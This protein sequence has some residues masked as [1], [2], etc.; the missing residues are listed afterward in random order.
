MVSGIFL[1]LMF[2][3]W[4]SG[5]LRGTGARLRYTVVTLGHGK[6]AIEPL[7][8]THR[9]QGLITVGPA[10]R[11]PWHDAV[12]VSEIRREHPMKTSEI[13]P[14]PGHQGQ[15]YRLKRLSRTE[16]YGKLSQLASPNTTLETLRSS[17]IY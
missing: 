13:E 7:C 11:A 16:R 10:P 6:P 4:K 2:G 9:R 12:S 15:V 1:L 3:V 5:L 14:W 17:T 8:R